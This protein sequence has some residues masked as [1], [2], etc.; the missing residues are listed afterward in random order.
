[1]S[2]RSTGGRAVVWPALVLAGCAS[3]ATAAP[4][5]CASPTVADEHA[6]FER[7][8]AERAP[9]LDD[10]VTMP[11]G[12]AGGLPPPPAAPRLR[13]T[14]AG[15]GYDAFAGSELADPGVRAELTRGAA[16]LGAMLPSPPIPIT[17]LANGHVRADDVGLDRHSI[18]PLRRALARS[19]G[20]RL[21]GALQVEVAAGVPYATLRDVLHTAASDVTDFW[22]LV[23]QGG[24]TRALHLTAPPAST[25]GEARGVL[26]VSPRGVA[27]TSPDGAPVCRVEGFDP[28]GVTACARRLAAAVPGT[29]TVSVSAAD[30][31]P[32]GRVLVVTA[33]A[34]ADAAG[35]IFPYPVFGEAR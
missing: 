35:P 24:S 7:A 16:S 27:A 17:D 8:L 32:V 5:P 14:T 12:A 13:V 22:L 28:S 33:L 2:P 15:I 34:R 30:D 21:D 31:V 20:D 26:R 23:R 3:A 4:P 11:P 19:R 1:M 10:P 6:A 29:T 25:A 18:L 9:P